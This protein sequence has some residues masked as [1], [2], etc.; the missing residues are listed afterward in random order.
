MGKMQKKDLI[1][2]NNSN[3]WYFEM[4]RLTGFP[5]PDFQIKEPTWWNDIV[6]EPSETR[7]LQTRK[8]HFQDAG[9][10]NEGELI[11]RIE[12][13]RIDWLFKTIDR[14]EGESKTSIGLF[15]DSSDIF[16][17]LMNKWFAL[18]TCPALQRLAFGAILFQ[19]VENRKAGYKQISKYLKS[20]ELDPE[21]SSDFSYR[22]NRPRDANTDISGLKINR[23]SNWSVQTSRLIEFSVAEKNIPVFKG[24]QYF[25]CRLELDINTV[26]ES[27]ERLDSH[28]LG[29]VFEE[30]VSFG[31]EI[32]EKGDIP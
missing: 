4:L 27:T 6:G 5:T 10:F 32:A 1:A 22:I 3:D 11:L 14:P 24:P 7:L 25:V 12:P 31:L 18:E 26:P 30:L 20:V 17:K 15:L 28:V 23:L 13:S 19:T 29:K 2:K 9:P 21:G 8:G 16:T